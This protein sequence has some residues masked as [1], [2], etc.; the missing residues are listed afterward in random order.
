MLT[1]RL[2]VNYAHIARKT[3][4]KREI[5]AFAGNFRGACPASSRLAAR[6]RAAESFSVQDAIM[7]Y[8]A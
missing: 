8:I 3:A 5:A 6:N 2:W 4:M 7:A 1:K